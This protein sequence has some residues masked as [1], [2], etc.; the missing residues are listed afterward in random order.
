V[1]NP[2]YDYWAQEVTYLKGVGPK[3][4]Q[5]L[6]QELGIRTFADLLHYFPRRYVDRTQLA[7]LSSL[8]QTG[9]P[10]TVV[11][12]LGE[13][14][15]EERAK[16]RKVLKNTL[17]DEHGGSADLVWFQGVK[18]VPQKFKM[19]EVVVLYGRPTFFNR[20]AQFAHPEME[21]LKGDDDVLDKLR[22]LPV[23]GSTEA[24]QR[25]GLDSKGL[26]K[27]LHP[28]IQNG[29]A[30]LHE[31]LPPAL[32]QQYGLVPRPEALANIHF[33]QSEAALQRAQYRLAFEELLLFQLI[34]VRRKAVAQATHRA[35]PFTQV[36][37]Y[38]NRFFKELLPFELTGAQKRVVK[39]IR[40]DVRKTYQMNRLVQ[41]DVGSGKTMV[42]V[43]SMLLA[44]DN[45][46]QAAL[47]APTE[48]LA[49][50]HYAALVRYLQ[51]LGLHTEMITGSNTPA[52]RRRALANLAAGSS[53]IAVGTH[54]LLE[55]PVVFK[56]LGLTVIDEQHKFGVLQRS[57][58]WGKAA[59]GFYPHNLIMTATPIPRTLAL[60]LYGDLDVSVIDEL[61]PGRKPITTVLRTE[62]VR[63]A[64]WGFL[65][66]Q[67]EAGRQVYV[68]YPLVE[69]SAKTDLMDAV[70]G[71]HQLERYFK[72]YRVGLVHGRRT[73]EEKAVEM[74]RFKSGRTH[75]L[76]ST[77]VIEVGVDVPNATVM[78]I[79]HAERFGLS[80]LHQLRGRVGRGGAQSYCILMTTGNKSGKLG[81]DAKKRLEAL[82]QTTDGFKLAQVDLELRG[83]GDFLGTRQSGLPE[84]A[85]AD[86]GRD[87]A[88]L[89]AARQAAQELLEQDADLSQPQH[90]PL[91]AALRAFEAKYQLDKI[92]A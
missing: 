36:G 8:P 24:L 60:T 32:L 29:S 55:D 83:P 42:A 7:Q 27:L 5:V 54:A 50:Q 73:A 66:K 13:F 52:E 48:V 16:G 9:A 61:P 3:R 59:Q 72:E 37:D 25:A 88:T 39:E 77:T 51:P 45:G 34:M 44:V 86:V 6:Q 26:R 1:A 82:V 79:E 69:E 15:T 28:L 84:F 85:I 21:P 90:A 56:N 58:L 12:T 38:F 76:V 19:G 41:G 18:W 71:F 22:I 67:L 20:R 4:A 49:T 63:L 68:V 70:N 87:T 74:Q 64:M 30:Y 91:R 78:V 65:R 53:S 46:F 80:Q 14:F 81:P 43:L 23:Y 35:Q 92:V 10:V 62:A 57:R 31:F 2:Q 11:G 40:A 47:M 75:I 33:P 17:H 89:A